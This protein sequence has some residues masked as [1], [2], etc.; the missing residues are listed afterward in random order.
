MAARQW[1]GIAHHIRRAC[2]YDPEKALN[3]DLLYDEVMSGRSMAVVFKESQDAEDLLGACVISATPIGVGKYLIVKV[4][5]GRFSAPG[6]IE[7]AHDQMV[8]IARKLGCEDGVMFT[9]RPQWVR[10]MKR[11]GLK[12]VSVTLVKKL[13]KKHG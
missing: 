7:Q 13:E 1:G 5:G 2:D 8:S 6:W 9:G 4:L 12:E 10:R 11:L 3:P